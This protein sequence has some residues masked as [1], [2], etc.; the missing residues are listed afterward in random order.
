M[1]DPSPNPDSETGTP[2]WAK[3]FGVIF[4]AVVLLFLILLLTRGAHRGPGHHMS[5]GGADAHTPA[6]SSQG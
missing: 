2:R 5:S 4:L 3:V 6:R 1:V